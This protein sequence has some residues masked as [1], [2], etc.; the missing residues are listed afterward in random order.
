[1]RLS[2]LFTVTLYVLMALPLVSCSTVHQ[3][4]NGATNQCMNVENHGFPVPGTPVHVKYCD[5]WQNQQWTFNN[6]NI[7]GVGGFCVDVQGS[8]SSEGAPIN[9]V[10]CDGRP[11]QNW[12]VSNGT[13]VGIGG[14][15]IDVQGGAPYN[16][17]PLI[18]ATCSGAP[19]QHWSVH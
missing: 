13:I 11:S 14:K 5:P 17:A 18:L 8:A 1:M 2:I 16:Q 12:I 19:S 7:V 10:P 4:S 3:L 15:C 6:G 9:Y